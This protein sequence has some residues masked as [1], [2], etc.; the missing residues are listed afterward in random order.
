MV[1]PEL[2]SPEVSLLEVGSGVGNAIFPLIELNPTLRVVALD[3]AAS[4]ISILKSN[5]IA[6]ANTDRV[7]A[8]VCDIAH[9]AVPVGDNSMDFVLCFFV[10]SA[11]APELHALVANKLHRCLKPGGKL[12]CRDYGRYDE[13]QLRFKKGKKLD[14]NFYVRQDGTCAFYFDVQEMAALF[15]DFTTEKCEFVLRQQAN[16]RLQEARYRV[17][18]EAVFV[19]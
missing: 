18:V 10:L 1:F 3:F 7:Q 6:E 15:T 11:I 17:W 8:Y 13:A 4:A 19:K 12:L 9:D 2:A 5:P 16:R 14:D